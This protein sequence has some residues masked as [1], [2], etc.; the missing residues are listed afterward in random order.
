M[1][2]LL[3]LCRCIECFYS[4]YP[5][6]HGPTVVVWLR[7]REDEIDWPD[8]TSG[9]GRCLICA[10]GIGELS[11]LS[12]CTGSLYPCHFEYWNICYKEFDKR[13][14]TIYNTHCAPVVHTCI[15]Y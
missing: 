15:I 12:A 8:V 2:V 11:S 14:Y 10:L 4:V 7:L 13:V 6:S 1:M 3:T 5:G 9:F